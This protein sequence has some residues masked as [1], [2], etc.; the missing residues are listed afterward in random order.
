MS[1]PFVIAELDS[2]IPRGM[3]AIA[4]FMPFPTAIGSTQFATNND[5]P[6]HPRFGKMAGREKA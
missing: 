4:P 1:G 6:T 2:P 3:S 5:P